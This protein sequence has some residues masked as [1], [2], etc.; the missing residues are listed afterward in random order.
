MRAKKTGEIFPPEK[1]L[2]GKIRSKGQ[3]AGRDDE[4][5][6]IFAQ[7]ELKGAAVTTMNKPR[8]K[9]NTDDVED[10]GHI[11]RQGLLI[12]IL[13]FGGMGLWAV[14]GQITGAVVAPGK[15]KIE[16]ERK[17]VQH[18]EGGIVEAILVREGQEVSEGQPLIVLESVQVDASTNMLR[19][20]LVT[21][22]AAQLRAEA[23]KTLSRELIWPEDLRQTARQAHCEDVLDNEYLNF[24]ARGEALRGQISLLEA[25]LAQVDAQILGFEDQIKAENRIIGTLQEELKAK[26]QLFDERYIE[27]SQILELE[28]TLATH[29][30]SRGSMRQSVAEARQRSAELQLRIEDLKNRFVEQATAEVNTLQNEI[31]QTR[32]RIRPLEDARSRLQIVAPVA[33]RVV[34]LKVHSRGGVVRPGEPLMDIVPEDN[35]LIVEIQVPVNKIAD[36]HIG[37]EAMVQLDAFDA[38]LVP[39]LTARVTYV[40][41]DRLEEHTSAG[42]MPYYLCYVEIDPESLKKEQ[43]YL[44]PGMPAT[45]F[46]T[47]KKRSVLFYMLEPLLKSW[48]RALRE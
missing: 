3:Y 35:P 20:Q 8:G 13:F 28:R 19:K 22:Q 41:A 16:S 44:A 34:D 2:M 9:R 5:Q 7:K 18:L 4:A 40:S 12:I 31:I 25:Q 43:V 23:E 6:P 37:Q 1:L 38:R 27:K 14:F 29:E 24:Q 30:G 33:G 17:T 15:I 36:I 48:D 11:I 47:T 42:T 45:V 26:R 21:Q 39:H 46:I 10:P 32:E